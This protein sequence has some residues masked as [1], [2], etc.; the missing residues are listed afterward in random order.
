[1]KAKKNCFI[2]QEHRVDAKGTPIDS[3]PFNQGGLGRCSTCESTNKLR[4][5]TFHYLNDNPND[6]M[7]SAVK[8]LDLHLIYT[9]INHV[10]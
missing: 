8:R 7:N 3:N 9:I 2:C 4:E 5:S 10:I 1:M 6:A